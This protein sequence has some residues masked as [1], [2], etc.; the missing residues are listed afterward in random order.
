MKKPLCIYCGELATTR[1]HVPPKILIPKENRKKSDKDLIVVPACKNCNQNFSKDDEYFRVVVSS[2]R[3][4]AEQPEAQKLHSSIK[5]S[6]ERPQARGFRTSMLRNIKQV[7][8][9]T[10]S[11]VYYGEGRAMRGNFTRINHVV[12]RITRGLYY[13]HYKKPLPQNHIVHSFSW[14]TMNQTPEGINTTLASAKWLQGS[15]RHEIGGVVQY[16]YTSFINLPGCTYWGF[17]FFKAKTFQVFT[18]PPG[19]L[20]KK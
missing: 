19:Q 5:R 9:L 12:E 1:D 2:I 8:L 11:G 16:K 10:P 18:F 6:L 13:H 7:P 3:H 17:T 15:H 4:V 14:E 20:S